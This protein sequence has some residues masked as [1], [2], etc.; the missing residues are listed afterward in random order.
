MRTTDSAGKQVIT[1]KMTDPGG[2]VSA[3]GQVPLSGYTGREADAV[4]R[5]AP[6]LAN[7]A[8]LFKRPLSS[9]PSTRTARAQPET[10]VRYS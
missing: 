2:H 5:Q 7:H 4:S 6:A 3:T 8:Q 10:D 1:L 9:M